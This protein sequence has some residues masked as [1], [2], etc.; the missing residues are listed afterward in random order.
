MRFGQFPLT[1]RDLDSHFATPAAIALTKCEIYTSHSTS[2]LECE[3][4]ESDPEKAGKCV[5]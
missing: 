3:N 4:V 2:P 5:Q 1:S